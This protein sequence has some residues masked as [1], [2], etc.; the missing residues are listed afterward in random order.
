[1]KSPWKMIGELIFRHRPTGEPRDLANEQP[2]RQVDVADDGKTPLSPPSLIRPFLEPRTEDVEP[3]GQRA[4]EAV[5]RD[6]IIP[7]PNPVA[8]DQ[9]ATRPTKKSS[10]GASRKTKKAKTA[11]IINIQPAT[12]ARRGGRRVATESMKQTVHAV[13]NVETPTRS[14]GDTIHI[15]VAE[16][17]VQ[18]RVLT[19]HLAEKLKQQNAQLRKMLERFGGSST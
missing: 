16:I 4:F 7:L 13:S 17:D 1:M 8:V 11:E 10:S 12:R 15:E 3:V 14:M 2:A 19:R 5:E 6:D 9:V 18:I